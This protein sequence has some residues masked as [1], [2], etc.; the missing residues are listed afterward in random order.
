MAAAR[1]AGLV[2]GRCAS[3]HGC[4]GVLD[5]RDYGRHDGQHDGS[6]LQGRGGK[7]AGC[8]CVLKLHGAMEAEKNAFAYTSLFYPIAFV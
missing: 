5:G 2:A 7:R 3:W 4:R 6:L 1:A 8:R